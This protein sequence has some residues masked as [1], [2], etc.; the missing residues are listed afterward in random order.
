MVLTNDSRHEEREEGHIHIAQSNHADRLPNTQTNARRD[1]PVETL[2]AVIRIDVLRRRHDVQVLGAI[3]IHRLA[4]HLNA[5]NLN[6]LVP[7]GQTTTQRRRK[8]L[9]HDAQL[10]AVLLAR[11]ATDAALSNARQ[12]EAGAPV[13]DLAHG[14]SVDTAI[15]AADALLAPD[16]H[17][18][19]HGA[20]RLHARSRD[21]VLRDLDRLHARAEAHGRVRLREAADHAARDAGH[22]GRGA[23]ALRIEL[24]LGRDEEQHGTLGRGFDPGPRN[25][26]LVDCFAVTSSAG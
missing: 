15:D 18:R 13:G 16:L 12:T 1:T 10:L 24:C 9:L 8:H 26:A 14:D 2:H 19:L 3:R 20:R 5:D 11:N 7:G 4:L 6:R 22:K 25:Q 21:L 23:E 17:E